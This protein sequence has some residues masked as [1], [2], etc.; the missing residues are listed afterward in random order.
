MPDNRSLKNHLWMKHKV[1]PSSC[2]GNGQDQQSIPKAEATRNSVRRSAMSRLGRRRHSLPDVGRTGPSR[3]RRSPEETYSQETSPPS[4]SLGKCP[5]SGPS[6]EVPKDHSLETS[7][8]P[9]ISAR[10]AQSSSAGYVPPP[11]PWITPPGQQPTVRPP[12]PWNLPPGCW[13]FDQQVRAIPGGFTQWTSTWTYSPVVEP[14][15][16]RSPQLD[17]LEDSDHQPS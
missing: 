1:R 14:E 10:S 17:F 4:S 15:L 8:Q 6:E 12:A 13:E 11:L 7:V 2:R 3:Q 5:D 16:G 9:E